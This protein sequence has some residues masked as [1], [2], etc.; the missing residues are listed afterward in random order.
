MEKI[1]QKERDLFSK[2]SNTNTYY[3]YACGKI[4][5]G[6]VIYSERDCAGNENLCDDCYDK[7]D[8]VVA[9]KIKEL[10]IKSGMENGKND[11]VKGG[12]S[13]VDENCLKECY[14]KQKI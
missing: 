6:V 3:C 14:D 7:V 5:N 12:K 2:Y 11:K 4:D 9:Q 8:K 13:Y 10:R 1:T